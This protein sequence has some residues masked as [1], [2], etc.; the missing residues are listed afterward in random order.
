[1]SATTTE[2]SPQAA[3]VIGIDLGTTN[4]ALTYWQ[5]TADGG[6]SA[7]IQTLAIPQMTAPG[8]IGHLNTLPS[9]LY[10]PHQGEL[11][12]QECALPWD[13]TNQGEPNAIIGAW[14]LERGTLIPDRQV[15]SAKSWL[16]SQAIDRYAD[17]LPWKSQ[18]TEGKC[19][20]VHASERYLAHLMAAF[21]HQ[22]HSPGQHSSRETPQVVLT[23]PASFDEVA[24]SLTYEAAQRA[25]LTQVTLLEEP[26]AAF[27][28][29]LDC[30]EL[31]WREAVQ[32]GDL[33][34]VCDV[35]GGTCDFSLIAVSAVEG[36]LHLE[37]I[38]V[39]DHLLLGG[40]NMDLALAY[41]LKSDL[42]KS[43]KNL[44]HWQFLSLVGSARS[45]KERLLSDDSLDAV[46]IAVAARGASLFANTLSTK[47]TRD[48]VRTVLVDGFLPQ[49]ALSD[50]PQT[51]RSAGIQEVGLT[52]VSDPAISRH[53]ARF[54]QRSWQNAQTNS[55]LSALAQ[56]HTAPGTSALIPT[57]VLFNGGVFKS[58]VMRRRLLDVL[59][60][61]SEGRGVN[62]LQGHDFELA[63]ARGAA[64]YGKLRTSGRGVRVQS[65][66]ARSYYVGLEESA[67][68]IPGYQ[69]PVKGLCLVPQ[70]TDE[71]TEIALASQRFGLVVGEPVDFRFFSSSV[72]AG[73]QP[74]ALIDDAPGEL[75]ESTRL[76][77]TLP[78]EGHK[79]GDI[80]AVRLDAQVTETGML[81]LY[82]HDLTSERRWNLEFNVRPY[83]H[84]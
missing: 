84:A 5:G 57:A 78:A 51:R 58:S 36:Q 56:G 23:V 26:L 1:M 28:A 75:D 27:Y 54:L 74:G 69:P 71:G 42:E 7:Q 3:L 48:H 10:I 31:T 25:G 37:R 16:C 47:L 18:I 29:W 34:L 38:S 61:W 76:S 30:N 35:G 13:P 6:E 17:V 4:S 24:R 8:Q 32:P 83:D 65:G 53:L 49:T 64:Y 43:G 62:E 46:P 2:S 52:Y 50:M 60:V 70:G 19:S 79:E 68:A 40:D 66:T 80:V 81:Q 12:A 14:A 15:S 59:G 20:P 55:K 11:T 44:D 21:E 67:P 41:T 82:M 63:V 77:I 22:R 9:F 39:G 33:V 72:R 73:D 45:A